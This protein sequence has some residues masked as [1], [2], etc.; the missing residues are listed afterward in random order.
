MLEPLRYLRGE[1]IRKGDAVR[2]HGHLA[3]I[4]FIASEFNEGPAGWFVK[5]YGGGGMVRDPS[6]SGF[7]FIPVDQLKSYEDLELIA[8]DH[9]EASA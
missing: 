3:R 5:Q 1:E 4:E 7:T 8:R 9:R 2:F 6:I